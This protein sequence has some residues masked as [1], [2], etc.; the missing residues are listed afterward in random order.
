M[1]FAS[2]PQ[3]S[4]N[5]FAAK[6]STKVTVS[7]SF[8]QGYYG[9]LG[10][11]LLCA[12]AVALWGRSMDDVG[13][14]RFSV[15]L[16]RQGEVAALNALL[17]LLE[18]AKTGFFGHS[19]AAL[20]HGEGGGAG[21]EYLAEHG[22]AAEAEAEAEGDAGDATDTLMGAGMVLP[23]AG[24]SSPRKSV[25]GATRASRRAPPSTLARAAILQAFST[26]PTPA[27]L[28][29]LQATPTVLLPAALTRGYL[30]LFRLL[31]P[32]PS[33]S[34]LLHQA[35]TDVDARGQ[36]TSGVRARLAQARAAAAP[37]AASASGAGGGS[38]PTEGGGGGL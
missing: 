5:V 1:R 37:L 32:S 36:L 35:P 23:T 2:L 30:G 16:A 27:Y 28:Y 8:V 12:L 29:R 6:F 25:R 17:T 31:S 34:P 9:V 4:A 15:T 19:V 22:G 13:A 38:S 11:L 26:L 21:G 18:P 24:F 14:A 20:V 3:S 33:A 10:G 7:A